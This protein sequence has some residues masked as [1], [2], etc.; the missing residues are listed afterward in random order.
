MTITASR[1]LFDGFA[2]SAMSENTADLD[3]TGIRNVEG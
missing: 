1:L 2:E 3:A